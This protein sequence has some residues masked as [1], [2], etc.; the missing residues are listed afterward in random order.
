MLEAEIRD[1]VENQINRLNELRALDLYYG[2]SPVEVWLQIRQNYELRRG[3]FPIQWWLNQL[4][5]VQ[6]L[7]QF[8]PNE[9]SFNKLADILQVGAL[10]A[11]TIADSTASILDRFANLQWQSLPQ[12]QQL[13]R[14]YQK[15]NVDRLRDLRGRFLWNTIY[16]RLGNFTLN[17]GLEGALA[18][19]NS[20]VAEARIAAAQAAG[21][22]YHPPHIHASAEPIR[23]G[24]EFWLY[25]GRDR[26]LLL[27]TLRDM[28]EI[29]ERDVLAASDV[30]TTKISTRA[31]IFPPATPGLP[32]AVKVLIRKMTYDS[33]LVRNRGAGGGYHLVKEAG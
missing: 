22:G 6:S 28:K 32:G 8:T 21:Q 33:L 2:P 24:R 31:P 15:K 14:A 27:Q 18:Y 23:K 16:Q 5:Y 11:S 9:Q 7:Q 1:R 17:R 4:D 30:T 12:Q 26:D 10:G 29:V 3:T 20:L 13:T 19:I 25:R